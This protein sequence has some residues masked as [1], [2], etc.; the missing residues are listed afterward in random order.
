MQ[1]GW[2]S[3]EA[4]QQECHVAFVV[5]SLLCTL[6]CHVPWECHRA[7]VQKGG[8]GTLMEGGMYAYEVRGKRREGGAVFSDREAAGHSGQASHPS[9][10]QDQAGRLL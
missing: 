10:L 2:L 1:Q 5:V 6:D 9:T 4:T 8:M 7:W 3:P